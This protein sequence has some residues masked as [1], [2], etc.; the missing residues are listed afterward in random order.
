M[1]EDH[2]KQLRDALAARSRHEANA[3]RLRAYSGRPTP[4]MKHDLDQSEEQLRIA[5]QTIASLLNPEGPIVRDAR[6]LHALREF[7]KDVL[8]RE[9]RYAIDGADLEAAALRHG[10]L[11]EESRLVPCGDNCACSEFEDAGKTS[12][13]LV[14]TTTMTGK[15]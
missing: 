8:D 9:Q 5:E 7:A 6:A 10:L 13:C 1:I 14:R 15:P 2:A 3:A 4:G 12:A 11:R